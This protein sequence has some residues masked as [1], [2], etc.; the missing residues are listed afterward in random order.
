MPVHTYQL[1]SPEAAELYITAAPSDIQADAP[2]QAAE[3]FSGI[4]EALKQ[5]QSKIVQERI[6][7]APGGMDTVVSA[8]SAAY[9]AL[10]DGVGPALLHT[11]LGG[12]AVSGVQV[13]AVTGQAPIELVTIDGVKCGRI[14]RAGGQTVVVAS[15]LTAPECDSRADQTRAMLIKGEQVVAAA[16]GDFHDVARTWMWLT[17][18]LEWYDEFN[19][20]RNE[21]FTE[22]GLLGSGAD[23][24]LPA[25]TGISLDVAQGHHCAMDLLAVLGAEGVV[26]RHQAG[27]DQGSAYDY[28][29]AF[30][31]AVSARTLAGRT[32]LVSGTAA[33]DE[34]GNTEHL[35]DPEAQVA[36]TIEHAQAILAA[37]GCGDSD[38]V[39]AIMYCKTP[40]V[41][42]IVRRQCADL[43]WP[44]IIA[45]CDVCRHDLLFETE[46]T[47]CPGN[48][49][50]M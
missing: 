34:A 10:D 30:S 45:V 22:R 44:Q 40:E 2:T 9:G 26:A 24:I 42:Q 4:A 27:G 6:L 46:L 16:G 28:G 29:S 21:F 50:K 17:D 41:E 23:P 36:D 48:S 33:I 31:R 20:V 19:L 13:Y 18:L 25:S 49:S 43:P 35:D 32:V 1:A 7:F 47:A 12:Q 11:Q 37:A 39:Q 3:V 15:A 14:V 38:V 8:R 5:T